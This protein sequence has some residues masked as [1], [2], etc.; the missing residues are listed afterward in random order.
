MHSEHPFEQLHCVLNPAIGLGFV[1]RDLDGQRS[2]RQLSHELVPERNKRWLVVGL[3][4]EAP[5]VPETADALERSDHSFLELGA[6]GWHHPGSDRLRGAVF[7]HQKGDGIALCFSANE[8][9][10]QR[11]FRDSVFT[12]VDCAVRRVVGPPRHAVRAPRPER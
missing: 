12:A 7:H 5:L 2:L 9:I 11:D 8:A 3:D 6:L 1:G 4:Q 10:I